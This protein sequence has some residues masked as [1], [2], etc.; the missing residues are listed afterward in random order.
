MKNKF[1]KALSSVICCLALG[2][3]L[4]VTDHVNNS[5]VPTTPHIYLDQIAPWG[6]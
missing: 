4:N 2:L 6:E 3:F 1:T 5:D